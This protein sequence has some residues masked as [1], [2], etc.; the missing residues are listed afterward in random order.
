MWSDE[1]GVPKGEI[2]DLNVAFALRIE[3][4]KET[5]FILR[6]SPLDKDMPFLHEFFGSCYDFLS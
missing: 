4:K 2:R 5:D 6:Q 1:G 3:G